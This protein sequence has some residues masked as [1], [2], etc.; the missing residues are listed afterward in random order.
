MSERRPITTLSLNPAIDH[1]AQVSRFTAGQVNRV[2]WEQA[3]AGGKGV[4]VASFLAHAG[5]QVAATGLL[6]DQNDAP[7]V[8]LFAHQG[9]ADRCVRVPGRTRVN[10]KIVDPELDQVTDINF[11]GLSPRAEDLAQ[12]DEIIQRL[13]ANSDWFVLT[14]S[15]PDG[16]PLD[17]YASLIDRLRQQG[18][19]VML[20]ASGAPLAAAVKRAPDIIKPNIDELGELVGRQLESQAEVLDAARNLVEQGIGLVAVSMGGDGA[21]FVESGTAL[22][23]QPPRVEVRSTVG[24]GDAMVAGIL[25]GTLRGLDL[26]ARA[27]LATAFSLAALGEVGPHLPAMQVVE[28]C[29]AR[30]DIR[31]LQ[32]H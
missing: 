25:L 6:G 29:I 31:L 30:V 1:T 26:A 19:Q 5:L 15:V 23:A 10:V 11:P 2:A 13:C 8:E 28:S 12:L 9:I 20:D 16:V 32:N 4:N 7:F 21:L 18:K 22:L 3:D 14:G 27:R 17:I 24:A